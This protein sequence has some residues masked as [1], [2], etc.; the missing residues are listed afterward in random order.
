[1]PQEPYSRFL[2][3]ELGPETS[4]EALFHVIPVPYEKSVS[5]GTGTTAGP[6]AILAASQQLELFDGTSI[7]AAVGI[8]TQPP[9]SCIGTPAEVLSAIERSVGEVL[10][11]CK[12]PVL[13]GGE[14][15]VTI[16]ALQAVQQYVDNCGIVQFDAHADLRD[17][18]E[19][20]PFSHACVMHRALDMDFPL[21]QIGVR[22]LSHEEELLRRARNIGHLDGAAI[23]AIGVPETILP[24]AFP[25][26]IYVTIDVDVLDPGILPAT[27]TPEPGGLGWYQMMQALAAVIRGRRVLGFDVVELAPVPGLHAADYTVA[28]LIYNFFGM[29]SR[30][31]DL[32]KTDSAGEA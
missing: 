9:L 32:G 27:G 19:A 2:E 28:R 24:S 6:A 18:Y 23:D 30:N 4:T 22:S 10:R 14:H 25:L 29:I 8:H 26:D 7:P 1:M 12:I 15:T 3:S 31:S 11:R 16:G 21:Y 20:S 17:T 13:L 5:Y